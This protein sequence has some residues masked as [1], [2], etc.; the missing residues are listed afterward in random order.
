MAR[1]QAV[2]ATL[3]PEI[4]LKCTEAEDLNLIQIEE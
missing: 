1:I 4:S 2:H 3:L